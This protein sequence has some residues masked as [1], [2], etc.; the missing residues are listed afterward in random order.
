MF[1]MGNMG[2]PSRWLTSCYYHNMRKTGYILKKRHTILR[3]WK[4]KIGL[5]QF[6]VS[7]WRSHSRWHQGGITWQDR[8]T[9]GLRLMFHNDLPAL[10]L[11][12]KGS[13]I[14]T[15]PH[16]GPHLNF[17]RATHIQSIVPGEGLRVPPHGTLGVC[18][19]CLDYLWSGSHRL[20]GNWF[21]MTRGQ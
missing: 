3:G 12:C 5:A 10:A 2:A 14:L 15:L 18:D 6:F 20:L 16:C 1:Q 21:W 19:I 17:V 4:S 13:T 7:Y 9:L 8:K 11:P